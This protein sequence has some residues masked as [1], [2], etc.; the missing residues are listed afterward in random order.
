MCLIFL[1]GL[2]LLVLYLSSLSHPFRFSF[3]ASLW[4]LLVLA[5]LR[6]IN[7][8]RSYNEGVEF[9]IRG[10]RSLGR[11]RRL[12]LLLLL[13]LITVFLLVG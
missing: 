6:V 11:L 5:R 13:G 7:S 4:P 9:F 12:V 8:Y 2:F 10:L 1:G 3:K